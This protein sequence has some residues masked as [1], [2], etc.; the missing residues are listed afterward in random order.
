MKDVAI[1]REICLKHKN[2]KLQKC[3]NCLI[4]CRYTPRLYLILKLLVHSLMWHLS[5]IPF[6]FQKRSWKLVGV[7]NSTT[8]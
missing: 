1:L 3:A 4:S 8:S 2:E 7:V 6:V 5:Y